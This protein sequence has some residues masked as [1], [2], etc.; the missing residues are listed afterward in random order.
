LAGGGDDKA[1][2]EQ[3][4]VC[5]HSTSASSWLS[6]ETVSQAGA[7]ALLVAVAA[8]ELW[9]A[10]WAAGWWHRS[11]ASALALVGAA[12][13]ARAVA[14]ALMRRRRFELAAPAQELAPAEPA[15]AGPVWAEWVQGY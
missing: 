9:L 15:P 11:A 5:V 10:F 1:L 7:G 2:P 8:A 3:H 14:V 13:L 6:P 12:L 4:P